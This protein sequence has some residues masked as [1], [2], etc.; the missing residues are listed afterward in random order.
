MFCSLNYLIAI[1][2]ASLG[3]WAM[4]LRANSVRCTDADHKELDDRKVAFEFTGK[5]RMLTGG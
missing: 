3:F 1:V 4:M 5:F 2:K